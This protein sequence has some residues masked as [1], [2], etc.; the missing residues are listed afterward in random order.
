[1][2]EKYIALAGNPN[3]GKSTIFN[4]LTGLKQ[5]TGNWSGKTVDIAF[6]RYMHNNKNYLLADLPGCYSIKS[7]SS[8]EYCA[9]EAI[10]D[11]RT[12]GIIVVCDACSLER[13]LNLVIQICEIS[14]NVVMAV[15]FVDVAKK[16]GIDIDFKK[17]ED[18]LKI[19]VVKVNAR[20]KTGFSELMNC[21]TQSKINKSMKIKYGHYIE[22]AINIKRN[23]T[24]NKSK[25]NG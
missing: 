13:N 16:R 14:E 5:H 10:R 17:L 21:I 8:E 3:V 20:K 6:G 9:A 4:A 12:D 22:T 23:G 2:Q 15:N 1:M 18:K 24:Q 25:Q 19:S 7:S 11:E